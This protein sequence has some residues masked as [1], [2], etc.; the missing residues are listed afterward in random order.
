MREKVMDVLSQHCGLIK[1]LIP[2][3]SGITWLEKPRA[4]MRAISQMH[5]HTPGGGS[6]GGDKANTAKVLQKKKKQSYGF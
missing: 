2:E 4:S 5:F 6:S 3:K 1:D